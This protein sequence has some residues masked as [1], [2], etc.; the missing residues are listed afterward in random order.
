M[1]PALLPLALAGTSAL[2][3]L[4]LNSLARDV[5]LTESVRAVADVT[6]SFAQLAQAGRY[7]DM[8]ALFAETGTL[9]WG[10][11]AGNLSAAEIS[12]GPEAIAKWLKTDAGAMDG[13]RPGSLDVIVA[14]NPLINVAADGKTAKARYNTWRF[15][16]DGKGES[17]LQGGIME[18]EYVVAGDM[19]GTWK[20]S[21]LRYYPLYAGN[22]SAGWRNVGESGNL[23]SFPF[24]FTPDEAGTPV[25]TPAGDAPEAN[26]TIA[27]L[28]AR[29]QRLNDEDAV[30]NLQ[31]AY[32]FYVDRRMW[33][34]V[35]DMFTEMGTATI[36]DVGSF[37]GPAGV[38]AAM[39]KWMG[40][41]GLD[42]GVLNA[43]IIFNTIVDVAPAVN[44]SMAQEAVSRGL[45]VGFLANANTTTG[46]WK[47]SIFSNR[48]VKGDD[49]LWRFKDLHLTP[50]MLANYTTGWA[51]GGLMPQTVAAS[52]VSPFISSVPRGIVSI[53]S[54][55]AA[56]STNLTTLAT[57]LA[58]SAARDGAENVSNAY[59]FFIDWID[60][61]G[62]TNMANIHHD[63]AHK[64]SPF[65]GFYQTR[66]R[67]LKACT[68]YYGTRPRLTREAISFHWRPQPV[69]LVAAD[70][71]SATLRAHLLQPET[72]KRNAGTVRGAIYHDQMVLE[73][74]RN[75]SSS[76][77]HASG[78]WRLWSVTIDEFYWTSASWP[79][80]PAGVAY[81][82]ANASNPPER[83]LIKQFR[84][85]ILLTEI[86]DPRETG[87]QG[88]TGRYTAWPE[89][90]RMWF[91]YRNPVSGRV[92]GSVPA[93]KGHEG[94]W[95]GC[96]PCSAKDRPGW[97]LEANGWMEPPTG[98]K[99]VTV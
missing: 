72:S 74:A 42:A 38:R 69:V 64:E 8:A 61:E 84:P 91:Q 33:T 9:H 48:F 88:G 3:E 36:D 31:H 53:G 92:P 89:I 63:L 26:T 29:I 10:T 21:L 43:H 67:I 57:A 19:A 65:A 66:A 99:D 41:E 76:S 39:E 96:V 50:I 97:S 83:D 37:M 59:G 80:G 79:K 45:E 87:F 4:T 15:Q 35:V 81:R 24:H 60:G 28:A 12:V 6:A 16:G 56:S 11:D 52:V 23:T 7:A 49:G 5:S 47:F 25:A 77:I 78:I 13:T 30:R 34:D 46:A 68:D 82:P 73:P 75:N 22:Y 71:R 90:Q 40:P 55:T 86:G 85:D 51:D 17:R 70:G 14:A 1:R 94:Y 62:C 93:G 95:P 2:A 27:E 54:T 98:P 32:G 20:F 18:N 58:R 44:G